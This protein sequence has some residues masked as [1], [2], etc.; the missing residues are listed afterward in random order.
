MI[1]G[2]GADSLTE[3]M[4][5]VARAGFH[6]HRLVVHVNSSDPESPLF[7]IAPHFKEYP[8]VGGAPTAYVCQNFV[9]EAPTTNV[10]DLVAQLS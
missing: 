3:Q 6:P 10:D 5:T 4:L 7:K 9:C 2:P 1:V 8:M